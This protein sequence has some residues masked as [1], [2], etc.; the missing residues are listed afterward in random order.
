MKRISGP[1][2][3]QKWF[4]LRMKQLFD[5]V[6]EDGVCFGIAA[7]K[8]QA[9]FS[10][11]SNLFDKRMKIMHEIPEEKFKEEL[12]GINK[13]RLEIIKTVKEETK[14]LRELNNAEKKELLADEYLNSAL[15]KLEETVD[16]LVKENKIPFS[17]KNEE[18]SRREKLFYF[19]ALVQNKINKKIDQLS[20]EDR[21]KFFVPDNFLKNSLL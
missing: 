16:K 17:K 19:N 20:E 21:I 4:I 14:P 1:Y 10:G 15:Q 13:K 11:D 9:I 8:M 5:N 6:S 3:D 7:M 18:L 12:E 2:I